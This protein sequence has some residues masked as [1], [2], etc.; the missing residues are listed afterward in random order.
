VYYCSHNAH[1]IRFY[2][3]VKE[4]LLLHPNVQLV[5]T[6][7]EADLVVFLPESM[8]WDR[9]ECGKEQYFPKMVILDEGDGPD[10]FGVDRRNWT[11]SNP[12]VPWHVGY[13]KRSYIRRSRG[14]FK[15]LMG[16]MTNH[17]GKDVF[18]MTYPVANAYVKSPFTKLKDREYEIVCTLRGSK[19][20]PAR[21]I[22][23]QWTKEYA[24][25]RNVTKAVTG[26]V[27]HE[28]R[29]TISKG[30]FHQLQTAQIVVSSNP[31]GWEGDFRLMEAMGSG[32]LV[33]VDNMMVPRP[34]P[35]V[36]HRHIVYYDNTNKTVCRTPSSQP[37]YS[38]HAMSTL[39]QTHDL[40]SNTTTVT[41][42]SLLQAF[43]EQLDYYRTRK[44]IARKVA[45]GG[46][47]HVL[48]Y[49]RSSCLID[50]VLRTVHHNLFYERKHI[51][52]PKPPDYRVMG[53]AMRD[54]L[55]GLKTKTGRPMTPFIKS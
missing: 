30:Y 22:V 18:P 17:H 7:D 29:R 51:T 46:Y 50:Y 53:Y 35:L 42:A 49:H 27:N 26:E 12:G 38:S 48:K 41:G 32:A 40:T 4:G 43:F 15:G 2:F 55:R 21:Q 10:L 13:F 19:G 16:W 36:N 34:H 14:S 45:V 44:N 23:Q 8:R 52:V 33:F 5:A 37:S 9:S 25:L 6:P 3:L 39:P 11:S 47:L 31:S 54:H 28:S 1:G 24:R 20:D